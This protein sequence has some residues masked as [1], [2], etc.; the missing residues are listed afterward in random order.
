MVGVAP[1][2]ARGF[3]FA[4]RYRDRQRRETFADDATVQV[5]A[6]VQFDAPR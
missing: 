1:F 6:H 2:C 3:R 4:L 5:T